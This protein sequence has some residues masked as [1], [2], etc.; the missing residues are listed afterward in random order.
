MTKVTLSP[1]QRRER[2]DQAGDKLR[3]AVESIV[4]GEQWQ[5]YLRFAGRLHHYSARNIALLM[6]QAYE[7]GWVD[8]NGSPDLGHV[9]GFRT[10]LSLGRHVRRGA[11]GLAVLA[12]C[13][14]RSRIVKLARRSTSS[15][16]SRSSTCSRL[17]RPTATGRSPSPYGRSS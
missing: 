3:K 7:R 12:P 10:W 1:E 2:L 14:R 4:T 11:R 5:D 17:A 16:A 9:A 13:G 6:Q 15:V 8:E